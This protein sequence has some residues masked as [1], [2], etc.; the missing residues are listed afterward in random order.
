MILEVNDKK[1][2][3]E[4]LLLPRSLYKNDTNFISPLDRGI[5]TIFDPAHNSFHT[6]GICKRWILK[7][8][9]EIVG[10][11]AA[12]INFEKN[13][14]PEFIIGGMGFFECIDNEAIAFQLFDTAKQW[15]QEHNAKAMDGPVNFGEN[16]KYW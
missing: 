9:K 1:S 3:K 16:V 8:D 14:T 10:R 11:I 13:K 6:H 4:F 15:L 2:R 7:K 12:F 5:E